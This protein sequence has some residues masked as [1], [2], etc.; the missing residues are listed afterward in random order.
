MLYLDG[1]RF[2]NLF[3]H[4]DQA[5][6][7]NM[8]SLF[9]TW[10]IPLLARN[11]TSVLVAMH[12]L[13]RF[14]EY[15]ENGIHSNKHTWQ[16]ILFWRE[17]PYLHRWQSTKKRS[18]FGLCYD[19]H[20]LVL[21]QC[22]PWPRACL[23]GI[24]LPLSATMERS[25]LKSAPLNNHRL[26]AQLDFRHWSPLCD[27]PSSLSLFFRGLCVCRYNIASSSAIDCK[28]IRYEFLLA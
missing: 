2:R 26:T 15:T 23:A 1:C 14:N 5:I 25:N 4:A 9:K 20:L 3:Q 10:V 21:S 19:C 22:S 8:V 17:Q 24:S 12:T 16:Q 28:V 27:T 11:R 18:A 7:A 6:I 13:R